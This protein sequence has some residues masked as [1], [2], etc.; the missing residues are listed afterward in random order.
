MFIAFS[1]D[2]GDHL[3]QVMVNLLQTSVFRCHADAKQVFFLKKYNQIY[4][5]LYQF[6]LFL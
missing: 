2:S 5:L 4:L 1:D 3:L 6:D